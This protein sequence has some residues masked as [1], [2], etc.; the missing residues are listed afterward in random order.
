MYFLIGSLVLD[1]ILIFSTIW[2]FSRAHRMKVEK[3]A[4]ENQCDHVIRNWARACSNFA[5]MRDSI[6]KTNDTLRA[7]LETA[8]VAWGG[9][10][11][12]IAYKD[13]VIGAL[14]G[15][16]KKTAIQLQD[17]RVNYDHL[18]RQHNSLMS[19]FIPDGEMPT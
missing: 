1:A 12:E 5:K 2:V 7:Q 18:V 19:K 9:A 10:R 15:N 3:K 16:L 13:K 17:L 4:A 8:E 14:C 6:L 11:E